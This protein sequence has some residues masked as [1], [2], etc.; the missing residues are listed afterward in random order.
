MDLFEL[1]KDSDPNAVDLISRMLVF[2]P[3]QR[4]TV[5]EALKHPFLAE[6]HQEEDEPIGKPVSS[7]DFDFELYSLKIPEF[8]DLIY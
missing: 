8:K 2:D 4:I 6:L 1:F 5:D 3:K 7:F